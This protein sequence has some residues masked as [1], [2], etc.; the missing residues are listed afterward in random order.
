MAVSAFIAVATVVNALRLIRHVSS[1]KAALRV[2]RAD[3]IPTGRH[4]H[5]SWL[6]NDPAGFGHQ[7]IIAKH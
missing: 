1:A 2:S 7:R 3:H 5:L 4:A 6:D